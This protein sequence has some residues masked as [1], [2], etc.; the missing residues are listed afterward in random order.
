MRSRALTPGRL[1]APLL[2]ALWV[3]Q[4]LLAVAHVQEHT[5]RYCS[6]HGT[7][8]E[9]PAARDDSRVVRFQEEQ[10]LERQA[11]TA[12]GA[13]RHEACAVL[14][15]SEGPRWAGAA[16][17]PVPLLQARREDPPPVAASPQALSS[18]SILDVAP[19]V[20]PPALA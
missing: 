20:S 5:H 18:L 14:G 6:A 16:H 12:E 10:A 7:F 17:Q 15:A 4:S 13:L 1:I 9:A 11:D 19:K 8:E 3:I 2:V